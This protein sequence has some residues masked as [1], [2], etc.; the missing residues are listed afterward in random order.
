MVHQT[1]SLLKKV[2]LSAAALREVQAARTA[3]AAQDYPDAVRLFTRA[4]ADRETSGLLRARLLEYRGECHWLLGDFTQAEA[5]YLAAMRATDDPDQVARARVRLGEVTDFKGAY[6]AAERIYQQALAEGTAVNNVMVIGRARR[7]LGILSRRHGNTERALTHL[8]QALAAFRQAG[9]A[10]EQARVLTSLGRTRHVRGEYQQ[11]LTAHGEAR[12]IFESLNDRWRVIQALNDIGECHQALYDM[13]QALAY[14]E[15]ALQ[16]AEV[17]ETDLLKPEIQRNLGIDLIELGRYDDGVASLQESLAGARALGNREQEA[18]ILY[19]LARAELRHEQIVSA[20][21][22]A[23]ELSAVA[24]LLDADRYQAL[25][26]LVR[27]ELSYLVGD[28]ETAVA[29]LN[30]AMLASQTAMDRGGLWKLHAVMSNV[31]TDKAVASVHLSIALEFIRQT[32]EPLQDPQ[33]RATFLY[34]PPV[35]AVL[36]AAGVSPETLL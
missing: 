8:T 28:R 33:L 6:D 11:A 13:A 20:S 34:A 17:E 16:M 35:L 15:Q 27:G 29:E 31:V 3:M 26:A 14:H 1:G 9:E 18:L 21:G 4:L 12:Q 19:H 2:K 25:A 7:G 36:Q 24:D 23:A 10:R 30:A 32:V 5:D 22:L